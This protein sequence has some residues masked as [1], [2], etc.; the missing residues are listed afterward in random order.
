MSLHP[1]KG[2]SQRL[3]RRLEGTQYI[4]CT[5]SLNTEQDNI[6]SITA[7]GRDCL[8]VILKYLNLCHAELSCRGSFLHG[9]KCLGSY[10]SNCATA[11]EEDFTTLLVLDYIENCALLVDERLETCLTEFFEA[12]HSNF[13]VLGVE[14]SV[15]IF[16]TGAGARSPPP[17]PSGGFWVAIS[18]IH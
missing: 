2:T 9:F 10:S 12:C 7:L 13:G 1:L 14:L 8:V 3:N 6:L 5:T 16:V 17:K 18:P 4:D 11:V 15:L